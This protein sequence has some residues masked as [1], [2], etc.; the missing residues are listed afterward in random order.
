[1]ANHFMDDFPRSL[2]KIGDFESPLVSSPDSQ[3]S[4]GQSIDLPKR[5][6]SKRYKKVQKTD[7]PPAITI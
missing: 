1:M 2:Q 4:V 3:S 6:G 7:Q 5:D